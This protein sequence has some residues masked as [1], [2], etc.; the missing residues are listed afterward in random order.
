MTYV[1]GALLRLP[2]TLLNTCATLTLLENDLILRH[3]QTVTGRSVTM[4]GRGNA[5]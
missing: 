4:R 2:P 5:A 1:V 3:R